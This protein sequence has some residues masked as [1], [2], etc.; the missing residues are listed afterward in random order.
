MGIRIIVIIDI[1]EQGVFEMIEY[2]KASAAMTV[3][4]SSVPR[5]K[6]EKGENHL[7]QAVS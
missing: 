1:F 7:P 3:D 2:G 4:L 5:T 6:F